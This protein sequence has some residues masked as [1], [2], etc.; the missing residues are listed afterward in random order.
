MYFQNSD[1]G[2]RFRKKKFPL[3]QPHEKRKGGF[4]TRQHILAVNKG[5]KD[6]LKT[7]VEIINVFLLFKI[8][9][10][11]IMETLKYGISCIPLQ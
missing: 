5:E 8:F 7:V 11:F 9:S 1:I 10:T 3:R 6:V 2:F 4:D